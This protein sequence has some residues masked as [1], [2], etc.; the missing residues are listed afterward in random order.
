MDRVP[1]ALRLHA[2]RVSAAALLAAACGSAPQP[3]ANAQ[4]SPEA[5]ARELLAAVS[6]GDEQ[7]LRTLAIDE[8]EFRE[9]I[10]PELPAA[11]PERNL[12]L[13]YVWGDLRQKSE[14]HLARL[15]RQHR[16]RQ[17]EL[18]GVEFE[19]PATNYGTYQVH[20]R[21]AFIVRGP[22]GQ[23]TVRLCGSMLQMGGGWKVFSFVIED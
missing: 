19:G 11:R 9:H 14:S 16:G 10:W 22:E 18:L 23:G 12:P 3:L 1:A 6:R 2:L 4:P 17:Y 20:R 7:R 8:E 5:L 13:S 21:A 15:V